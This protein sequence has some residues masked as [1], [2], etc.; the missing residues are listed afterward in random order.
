MKQSAP[1]ATPPFPGVV[2]LL[3]VCNFAVGEPGPKPLLACSIKVMCW[4]SC[5][6]TSCSL[7]VSFSNT[8]EPL[9]V[10]ATIFF[11]LSGFPTSKVLFGQFRGNTCPGPILWVNYLSASNNLWCC[12]ILISACNMNIY[13]MSGEIF[14]LSLTRIGIHTHTH[15]HRHRCG[16]THARAYTLRHTHGCANIKLYIK[17]LDRTQTQDTHTHGKSPNGLIL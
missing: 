11:L 10:I 4:S 17:L 3:F 16:H 13:S 2:S 6:A 9:T 8:L 1:P 5:H 14:N 15:T 12:Y 7:S